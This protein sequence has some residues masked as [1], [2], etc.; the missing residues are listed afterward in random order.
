MFKLFQVNVSFEC[1]GTNLKALKRR[2]IRCSA[3]ATITHLKK[4]IAKKV[5]TG[6]EKFKDVSI[7]GNFNSK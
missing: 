4:F 6:T 2:F 7:F 3:Q 5:L 1:M